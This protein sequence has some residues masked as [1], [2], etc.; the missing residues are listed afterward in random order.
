MGKRKENTIDA[1]KMSLKAIIFYG[2]MA[3]SAQPIHSIF[4]VFEGMK[5]E[6]ITLKE[7]C[8]INMAN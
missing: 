7:V 4:M 5:D 3:G 2:N 1:L 6:Y 8:N